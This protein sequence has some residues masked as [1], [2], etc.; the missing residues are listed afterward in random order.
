M[1]VEYAFDETVHYSYIIVDNP[2]TTSK[3]NSGDYDNPDVSV[4]AG[5][6]NEA[7]KNSS[8]DDSPKQYI[9]DVHAA[10]VDNVKSDLESN[11]DNEV[12]YIANANTN[13]YR[14]IK[15]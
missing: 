9:K 11:T 3:F 13:R 12:T 6:F 5:E 4:L 2:S 15:D 7:I 8:N 1:G 10:A 14:G